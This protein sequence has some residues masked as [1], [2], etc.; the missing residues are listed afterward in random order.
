MHKYSGIIYGI[1]ALVIM[2][3][4]SSCSFFK[5]KGGNAKSAATGW[6]YNDEVYKTPL[7]ASVEQETGPN[8]VF[9]E[10]GAFTMG[11]TQDRVM[12]DWDNLPRRVTVT[13]FYMD[14]SEV[15][16]QFYRDFLHWLKHV[17]YKDNNSTGNTAQAP[18]G[19]VYTM[20]LPDTLVWLQKMSYN[21]PMVN[22][23]LR[24]PAYN[25]YP[26]VG[27]NWYQARRYAQWRSDRVNEMRLI[28]EGILNPETAIDFSRGVI[29]T[30]GEAQQFSVDSYLS[31]NFKPTGDV[32]N[33]EE[34]PP[35]YT[36][37]AGGDNASGTGTR[38]VL[39]EDG[40]FLPDYRLPTEAEWEYAAKASVNSNIYENIKERKRYPWLGTSTR[41]DDVD[42]RNAYGMFNANFKR[43]RG[44]Y[45]GIAGTLNDG[46]A[47]PAPVMSYMPNDFGIY[48]L[49]GNVSEWVFDIY[50]QLT[51]EDVDDMNPVRGNYLTVQDKDGTINPET[52][53]VEREAITSKN[54][55]KL[56]KRRNFR[57][58][59]YRNY[60][61]GD[62][63]SLSASATNKGGVGTGNW[64]ASDKYN[65]QDP[66]DMKPTDS[67]Y[68]YYETEAKEVPDPN[69]NYYTRLESSDHTKQM[70]NTGKYNG[71]NVEE[72][73]TSMI[74]DNARVYKGGSWKD[75]AYYLNPSVRRFLDADLATDY[76]G[77][78]CVM[79]RVGGTV[80][81]DGY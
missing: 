33:Q 9:V 56:H 13:S 57:R 61:D 34:L 35:D 14:Q 71:S 5:S 78:R 22:L 46:Y 66:L 60:L 49:G 81:E 32:I 2:T 15:T 44:D 26:V 39:M 64:Q 63:Q 42:D 18:Y 29:G 45:M 62:W 7:A 31:G 73:A 69:K 43:G 41:S 28:K 50:R 21:E 11:A 37:V 25:D 58:A 19:Y 38:A 3:G 80:P 72:E 10:G 12:Y 67:S 65:T 51:F 4:M 16:N 27:V 54:D 79:D 6:S 53:R 55:V 23:Y 36:Q 59:D 76:L 47:R 68:R 40:I 24:H 8:L 70:Y 20:A 17:Y 30:N 74:N 48:N 75:R 77:F 1:F 52:N